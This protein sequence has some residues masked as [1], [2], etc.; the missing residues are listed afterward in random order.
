MGIAFA[1]MQTTVMDLIPDERG[2]EG[3]SFY[4]LNFILGTA[5]GPFLGVYISQI[6]TMQTIFIVC[7]IMTGISVLLSIFTALPKGSITNE[8]IKEMKG[9]HFKGFVEAKAL[10][11]A[12]L[13]GILALSFSGILSFLTSYSM[14]INLMTAA[15]FFFIVYSVIVLISRPI[16]GSILDKKGDNVVMYAAIL[17]F[18][19]GL[20]VLSQAGQCFTLLIG[21]VLIGLG[22][23]NL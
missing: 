17:L 14:E 8:Q 12:V 23:G 9:F 4:T 19:A 10:P 1:V 18:S 13:M 11:I 7:T 6:A 20:F 3:I 2:A 16:T 5:I 15:S 22:F 21:G